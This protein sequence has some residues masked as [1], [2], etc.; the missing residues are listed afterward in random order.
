MVSIGSGDNEPW[1]TC[2]LSDMLLSYVKSDLGASDAIDYAALF[3]AAEGFET[4]ADPEAF[5]TDAA[6]WIPLSILRELEA[7]CAKL[8]GKKDVAYHAA[9]AYF[10]PGKRRLPSVFEIIVRVLND[11]RSAL[12]FAN[13]C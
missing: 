6:N 1:V 2:Q 8:A 7:Q 11:V 5:L 4:P 12:S 3:H 13:L 9:K 10:T